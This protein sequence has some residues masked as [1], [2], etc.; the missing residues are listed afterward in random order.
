M[1]KIIS[2]MLSLSI[3]ASVVTFTQITAGAASI[4]A[5]A[6]TVLFSDDFE[7]YTNDE[8]KGAFNFYSSGYGKYYNNAELS[9]RFRLFAGLA[10]GTYDAV[11]AGYSSLPE[12]KK[13]MQIALAST[14]GIGSGNSLKV[15]G[16]LLVKGN[17]LTKK[18]GI[19]ES[20]IN[21][22]KLVFETSFTVPTFVG[23]GDAVGLYLA[24]FSTASSNSSAN[25][26]HKSGTANCKAGELMYLGARLD[27]GKTTTK[28]NELW[29][30]GEKVADITPG[31]EYTYTVTMTPN[32]TTGKYDVVTDLNGTKLTL[33]QSD[34]SA[35][36]TVPAVADVATFATVQVLRAVHPTYFGWGYCNNNFTDNISKNTL[37][38]TTN[39]GKYDNDRTVAYFDDMSLKAVN[40][41]DVVFKDDFEDYEVGKLVGTYGWSKKLATN[42]DIDKFTWMCG[43]TVDY[44]SN[45]QFSDW[46][47]SAPT[48]ANTA[49]IEQNTGVGTGKALKITGQIGINDYSL[50]KRSNLNAEMAS[51]QLEFRAEFKAPISGVMGEG[52]GVWVLPDG[53]QANPELLTLSNRT[54][55]PA[56]TGDYIKGELMYVGSRTDLREIS[57]TSPA[58]RAT[59]LYVFGEKVAR[60]N[61]D[62]TYD[63]KVTLTPSGTGYTGAVTLNGITYSLA[64]TNM[65][66][67]AQLAT[68]KRLF[69]TPISRAWMM[70]NAGG[71]MWDSSVRPADMVNENGYIMGRTIG[72][73]DNISL[74][75]KKDIT[76]VEVTASANMISIDKDWTSKGNS[77]IDALASVNGTTATVEIRSNR[78]QATTPAVLAA[79]YDGSDRVLNVVMNTTTTV[80]ATDAETVTLS[81]LQEGYEK[82]RVF[83][84]DID[85]MAPYTTT[86]G[87]AGGL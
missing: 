13:V 34:Y 85:S 39:E 38:V 82:V 76:S 1:K 14:S 12:P 25:D 30:F 87:L 56:G 4:P 77:F 35:S 27:Q 32:T 70:Y 48:P 80:G 18:I 57:K 29:T 58:S 69:A 28:K 31:T 9:E 45:S 75:A 51:R 23:F 3:I 83:V 55:I 8:G 22:K 26:I 41:Q 10:G 59:Y 36:S 46:V 65:P 84:W 16:E 67:Q 79:A 37:G 33:G 78:A 17:Q 73:L 68:Y 49:L 11:P 20:A 74:L 54:D 62:A 6:E 86:I 72:I 66:T 43:G 15:A 40:I 61:P 19:T 21:G 44:K 53:T 52:F 24:P 64:G 60:L 50:A 81:G 42:Y 47:K 2:L 63:L 5:P 71:E 7:G